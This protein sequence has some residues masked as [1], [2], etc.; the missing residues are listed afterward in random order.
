MSSTL[1]PWTIALALAGAAS[2]GAWQ[3]P[4]ASLPEGKGSIRGQVIDATSGTPVPGAT[5]SVSL[6]YAAAQRSVQAD[7]AGEFVIDRLPA[8]TLSIGARQGQS[9]VGGRYG[10]RTADSTEQPFEL[11]DGEQATGVELRLWRNTVISGRVMDA[12]GAPISGVTVQAVRMTIVNG[13]RSLRSGL[14][15]QSDATGRYRIDRLRPGTYGAAIV[16]TATDGFFPGGGASTAFAGYPTTYYPAAS[17]A[18]GASLFDLSAGEERDGVDF[19]LTT[20][21]LVSAEGIVVGLPAGARSPVVDLRAMESQASP[22]DVV[23]AKAVVRTDGRFRFPRVPPGSYV[24]RTAVFPT[25]ERV[26]GTRG[27][28]QSVSRGGF[29]LVGGAVGAATELPLTPVPASPTLWSNLPVT[30]PNGDVTGLTM[31]LRPAGRI[32][33]QIEFVGTSPKPSGDQLLRTPVVLMGFEDLQLA[34]IPVARIEADRRFST[35]GLPP[36]KYGLMVMAGGFGILQGGTWDPAWRQESLRFGDRR[37]T[38]IEVP[39]QNK[40]VSGVVITFSDARPT[41]LSGAV[42][43]GTGRVR[44]D[45]TI[46]VFPVNRQDWSGAREIRPGRSGRYVA[47]SLPPRE[48]FVA[49]VTDEATE[50]WREN[51]FLEKLTLSAARVTIAPSENTVVNLSVR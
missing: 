19:T 13:V 35:V 25:L 7:A 15:V 27:M 38:S 31:T 10:Q 4:Q 3:T 33:G 49:A 11:A 17:S 23:V 2:V 20:G 39:D 37:I 42:R 14:R 6:Q 21:L 44:P 8:A 9:Y 29:G 34:T 32:Q 12:T 48:Y 40:D 41:E 43:D 51:A 16:A 45:A 26:P 5:V 18:D 1:R 50:L 24:L 28:T 22:A 30:I 47:A 36:G 46:Y